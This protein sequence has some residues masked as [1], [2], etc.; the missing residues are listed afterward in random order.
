MYHLLDHITNRKCIQNNFIL[1]QI[2]DH[3]SNLLYIVKVKISV[4]I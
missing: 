1:T 3:L 2:A 4:K